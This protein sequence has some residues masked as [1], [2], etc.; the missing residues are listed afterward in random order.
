MVGQE[1]NFGCE[2]EVSSESSSFWESMN[3]AIAIN[4]MRCDLEDAKY[5]LRHIINNKEL[6]KTELS[7]AENYSNKQ[8]EIIKII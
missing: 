6:L 4:K 1:I 8:A 2:S 3:R 5:R 7:L